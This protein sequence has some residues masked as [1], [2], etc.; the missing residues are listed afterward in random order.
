M[1]D[2]LSDPWDDPFVTVERLRIRVDGVTRGNVVKVTF[3]AH[4]IEVLFADGTALIST[5][6]HFA[7]SPGCY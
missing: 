1:S 2:N 3:N 4:E 6:F 7:T 5:D